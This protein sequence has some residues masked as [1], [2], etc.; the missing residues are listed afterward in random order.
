MNPL[1]QKAGELSH[2]Q[3]SHRIQNIIYKSL[4]AIFLTIDGPNA[5]GKTT[6]A[7]DVVKLALSNNLSVVGTRE[8]S[9][10]LVGTFLR[11]HADHFS[12]NCLAH[13]V[14]A[15][16]QDHLSKRIIPAGAS[17]DLVVSARYIESSL[18][19]QG[20]DGLSFETIWSM[21]S[22]ILRPDISILLLPN[23]QALTERLNLRAHLS[24]HERD[25][26]PQDELNGYHAAQEFLARKGFNYHI[27]DSSVFSASQ[28]AAFVFELVQASLL[29]KHNS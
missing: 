10:G 18:V 6:V 27:F 20:L 13:L 23:A 4:K 22:P 5:S 11:S 26:T 3:R 8:P 25:F 2:L 24:R 29:Q 28:I 16:R 14:A 12:G 15:D 21:N 7:T 19:L 17:S 1:D 9:D